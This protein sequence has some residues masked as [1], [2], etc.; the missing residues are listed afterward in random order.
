[1]IGKKKMRMIEIEERNELM[2]KKE[3]DKNLAKFQK[4][5]LEEKKRLAKQYFIQLTEDSYKKRLGLE[6]ENDE[7]LQYAEFWIKE[8]KKQGK[9]IN[10]LLLELKRYKSN[11]NL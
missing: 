5:Q 7:F 10:P 8:Y 3:R 4:L 1:M 11:S 6:M 9:N 2:A